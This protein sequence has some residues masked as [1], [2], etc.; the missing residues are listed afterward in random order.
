MLS[1][2]LAVTT[3][4]TILMNLAIATCNSQNKTGYFVYSRTQIVSFR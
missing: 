4:I 3:V 1:Q 2:R